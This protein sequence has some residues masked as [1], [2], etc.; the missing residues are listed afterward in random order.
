[1]RVDFTKLCKQIVSVRRAALFWLAS[2]KVVIFLRGLAIGQWKTCLL[3]FSNKYLFKSQISEIYCDLQLG[4]D[5][6][7]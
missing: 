7:G 1:M 6:T 4:R 5:K 3:T 2:A